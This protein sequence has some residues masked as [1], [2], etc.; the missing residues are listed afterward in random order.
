MNP[1]RF[2]RWPLQPAPTWISVCASLIIGITLGGTAAA[3]SPD[4]TAPNSN[5]EASWTRFRGPGGRGVVQANLPTHWSNT[6]NLAWQLDLPGKGSSSPVVWG[7]RIFLTAFTG[8]GLEIESPGNRGDLKLHL[9]CIDLPSGQLVW[10]C[11][12]DPSPSEQELTKRVAEHGYASPTPCVDDDAVYASFGPSGVVAVSHD[13]K[14]LWRQDTGTETAGFGAAASPILHE[15][16]VIQNASIE[17]GKMFGIEKSTGQ[18]RWTF[19]GIPKAW[20]TPT[21]VKLDDGQTE[22]IVNRK[23]AIV[24]FDPATGEQLWICD[25]IPDYVVPCVIEHGG[26]LYCSGGRSNMTFVVRPGGRGDVSQS[27]LVWEKSLGANVTSPIL[28]N[29]HLF[30]SHDKSI[31]LCLR[32]SDG[33]LMFRERMPTR[34]RVYGSIVSDGK[35]LFLTTRDA[36]V[37]VLD[38]SPDYREIATNQLGDDNEVFNATPAIAGDA[39]LLRSDRRLYLI[40][41]NN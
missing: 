36:G 20:T 22:L 35:H 19:D 17:S 41:E 14:L 25:A 3:Q 29:G 28:V 18:I 21:L 12:I 2:T 40:R 26:L 39:M 9:L 7:N 37:L 4:T 6:K 30:W 31:A 33:E 32:A 8:Y 10:D 5:A 16:L 34:S 27:H 38:A 23:D 15:D 13:G 11:R 24:G 1:S